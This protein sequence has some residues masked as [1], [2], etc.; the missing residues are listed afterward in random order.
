MHPVSV[1]G[2]VAAVFPRYHECALLSAVVRC[3]ERRGTARACRPCLEIPGG[4]RHGLQSACAGQGGEALQPAL[5]CYAL[6]L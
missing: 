4:V 5:F 2:S 6:G 1:L 3:V